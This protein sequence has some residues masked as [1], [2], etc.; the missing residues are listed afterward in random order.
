MANNRRLEET[1]N[2]GWLKILTQTTKRNELVHP[3]AKKFN[4]DQYFIVI[5]SMRYNVIY[6]DYD[7]FYIYFYLESVGEYGD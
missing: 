7:N 2:D 5:D 1:F 4:K 6:A 3:I